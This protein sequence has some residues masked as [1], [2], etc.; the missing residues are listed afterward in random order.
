M[1][2]MSQARIAIFIP[3]FGDGGVERML[4]NLA[5]GFVQAGAAVSFVLKRRDGAY[6]DRLLPEVGLIVFHDADDTSLI[7]EMIAFLREARPAVVL[8]AKERDDRIALEV[9]SR[10]G[11]DAPRFFLRA[12][13]SVLSREQTRK[14]YAFK[15]WFHRRALKK[16][17]ARCDGILANSEGV[18]RELADYAGISPERIHIVP[19]PTVTPDIEILS[20]A[21]VDHPWFA[22][23]QPPVIL[24][25]G[26]LSRAKDFPTLIQAFAELRKRRTCR[27]VI[28]GE[29]GQRPSLEALAARLGVAEDVELLGFVKNPF[30]FLARAALFALS[31]QREGCPNVLIEALAVGTP[32]VATDCPSGPREILA[33]GRYGPLVPVGD[34]HAMAEA[35]ASVLD[36]SLPSE[37]LQEAA[38]EYTPENSSRAYLRAFGLG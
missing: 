15:R 26:R 5:N 22:P 1:P 16:L 4:V 6:L 23:A 12:G 13:T 18:A 14:P 19:N 33:G 11:D 9:K 36:N 32:V 10:L 2:G 17:C 38:G 34:S 29:G 28:L 3:S 7:Q 27:L 35:M 21:S 25:V 8:S 37:V 31:S 24:G 20:R 30:A